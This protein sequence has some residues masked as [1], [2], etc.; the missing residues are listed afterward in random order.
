MKQTFLNKK[1]E[2][3]LLLFFAGWGMD[4][5]PFR[6]WQP[7]GYD[8]MICYDYRSLD[9]DTQPLDEYSEI[10]LVAWSMGVWV[11]SQIMSRH[12]HLPITE[13]IAINGTPYPVDETFGIA[14]AI[15][16]GTLNGLNDATLQKFQRRMCKSAEEYKVFQTIAPQRPVEELKEE[17]ASIGHF[18]RNHPESNFHWNKAIIGDADRIFLPENQQRAWEKQ[19]T[20]TEHIPEGHFLMDNGKWKMENDYAAHTCNSLSTINPLSIIHYPLSIKK[21]LIAERFSKAIHSYPEEA[22]VQRQIADKM[23]CLVKQHIPLPCG[24]I[25]EFGCGTGIY[26][27]M[28]LQ[29]LRPESL[30]LNDLC[31]EMK[32]CCSDLLKHNER[33]SFLPGDA[34]TV[35]FPKGTELITSCSALQWFESPE[36][37]FHRCNH[38]L[39]QHGYFAFSTFG[40]ENMKEVR[41]LTGKGLPY[42][43][44]EE[45]ETSLAAHFEIIH[46]EEEIIPMSFNAPMDVLY[47]L[48]Q[49]GVTGIK[50]TKEDKKESHWTRRDISRFCEQYIRNFSQDS[51]VTLTYHPIYIIAKK[52]EV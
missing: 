48:K 35:A 25:V 37:F 5:T 42:L 4:E 11:A 16:E 31:R 17:L 10:R 13:S 27:R 9:F 52:K 43:S 23:I 34:E 18:Y 47:H 36:E 45:L 46:S 51:S 20:K 29:T 1:G 7:S 39:A 6:S 26:S 33:V 14:P 30:L 15:F 32:D 49:T 50:E 12:D 3:R 2:S 22:N 28:L 44:R 38:I 21:S 8:C 40:K 24:R 19:G 41:Q